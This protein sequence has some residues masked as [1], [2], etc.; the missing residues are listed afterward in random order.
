MTVQ[1]EGDYKRIVESDELRDF[2]HEVR[3]NGYNPDE[4]RVTVQRSA[5]NP[6][7]G[8]YPIRYAVMVDRVSADGNSQ[9]GATFVGGHGEAWV[10]RFAE[11]LVAGQ[12]DGL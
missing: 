12:F 3:R 6:A 7:S 9:R 5:P 10:D 4:F 11:A 1:L 2:E 8:I